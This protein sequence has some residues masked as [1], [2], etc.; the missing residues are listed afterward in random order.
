MAQG[1]LHRKMDESIAVKHQQVLEV[2][3]RPSVKK[4]ELE[5]VTFD[6]RTV[7]ENVSRDPAWNAR[8]LRSCLCVWS[9]QSP[10]LDVDLPL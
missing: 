7:V 8:S 9:F 5:N 10:D 1:E 3:L 4:L 2:N 6:D